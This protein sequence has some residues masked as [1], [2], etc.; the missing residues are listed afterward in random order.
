MNPKLTF[1][2][3]IKYRFSV[4]DKIKSKR[5][6]W[7]IK[8]FGRNSGGEIIFYVV[9][10]NLPR[11]GSQIEPYPYNLN[12]EPQFSPDF[13]SVKYSAKDTKQDS[14]DNSPKPPKVEQYNLCEHCLANPGRR[15][16]ECLGEMVE[17]KPKKKES[18]IVVR[19]GWDNITIDKR[20]GYL[21]VSSDTV[22]RHQAGDWFWFGGFDPKTGQKQ[23]EVTHK[24][25][26]L[27]MMKRIEARLSVQANQ[28]R[29][30]AGK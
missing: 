29:Y 21:H 4:G 2:D 9:K 27:E 11:P 17:R 12:G 28:A 18:S 19:K 25:D 16:C 1:I 7:T 15:D 10:R 8:G 22:I 6:K 30:G 23:I 3:T 14:L 26:T 20:L 24:S 5:N 13:A